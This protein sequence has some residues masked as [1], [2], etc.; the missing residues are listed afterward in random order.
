MWIGGV[1]GTPK[2]FL[3]DNGIEFNNAHYVGMC[4]NLNIDIC[5]SAGASL[6]QNG[7]SGK[8]M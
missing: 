1:L 2:K 6:W 5:S 3:I 7:I 4:E 8:I